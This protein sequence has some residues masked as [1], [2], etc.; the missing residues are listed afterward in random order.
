MRSSRL[1]RLLLLSTAAGL[2]V[3]PGLQIVTLQNDQW[4]N[5]TTVPDPNPTNPYISA[6]IQSAGTYAVIQ[7]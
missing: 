6:T 4:V 7:R 1:A 5:V 3:L 2:L